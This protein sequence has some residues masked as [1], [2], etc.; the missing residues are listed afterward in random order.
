MEVGGGER[1]ASPSPSAT[2]GILLLKRLLTEKRS[3]SPSSE[4][5]NPSSPPPTTSV[6]DGELVVSA[7][8]SW[9]AGSPGE[10]AEG[11]HT[12]QEASA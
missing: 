9:L 10:G 11:R 8:S 12:I 2:P 6:I 5:S 4:L 3:P 7:L 1:G